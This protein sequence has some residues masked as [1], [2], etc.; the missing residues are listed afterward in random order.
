[1]SVQVTARAVPI[2][3]FVYMRTLELLRSYWAQK[4]PKPYL[5]PAGTGPGH[6]SKSTLQKTFKTAL[7]QSNIPKK[8]S[9]LEKMGFTCQKGYI[10]YMVCGGSKNIDGL[11][12]RSVRFRLRYL[13]DMKNGK[14]SPQFPAH[15]GCD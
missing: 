8:A 11:I 6:I 7:T 9:V 13:G 14:I 5:F 4:R 1:M 2:M 3:K 10:L 12:T 15:R